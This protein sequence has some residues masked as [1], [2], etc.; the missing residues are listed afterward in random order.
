MTK[1]YYD[2]LGVDRNAEK[3]D[4]KKAYK[5]LAKKYHPDLNK[6]EGATEKFKE[7]N[8]AASVLADD[9][10]RKQYDQF[11]NAEDF[12]KASGYS[13]FDSSDYAGFN[14]FDDIFDIFTK[15]FGFNFGGQRRGPQR[16]NDLLYEFAITL[17]EAS[18]GV[19]K[20]IK[21]PRLEKCSK[22]NG[23]GAES[24]SDVITCTSCHGSG[25]E[26]KVTRTPFGMV[27]TT[28]TC[29]KCKGSGEI[30][31]NACKTCDGTGLVRKTR[32]IEVK[33]P[34]GADDGLRLRIPNEGEAGEKGAEPGDLYIEVRVLPH[35][36]FK[37]H[38]EDLSIEVSIPFTVAALGGE[39][40]VP[41]LTGKAALKI[42]PGTQTD[43]I[44]KMKGKGMP[45]LH[46]SEHGSQN[47]KI[48]INIPE[49]LSKK[50]RELLMEF[51]KESKKSG[52]FKG[53][54]E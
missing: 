7:I 6:E 22:C 15:G 33:I 18:D 54:F 48:I 26:K 4:I 27:Q 29:S 30:I 8:E 19:K 42:P 51:D 31:K 11:G 21:V 3:E 43:T 44:F 16:G 46:S 41:T 53:M 20:E 28:R 24:G 9:E 32:T 36:V 39:I 13:G 34:K 23:S 5:K 45:H 35:N 14:D 38:G 1:D 50:Q 40:K 52:F 12:K 10:K 37:R 2:V 49:K 25:Y 17:E 47:V